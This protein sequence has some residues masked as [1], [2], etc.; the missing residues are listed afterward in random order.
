MKAKKSWE[1]KLLIDKKPI[2]K[3]ND[4]D[5]ADIPA[6][7]RM[8]IA[9]PKIMDEYVRKIPKGKSVDTGT[10]RK[11]L[12]AACRADFT[13][14]LTTGIFLRIVAEAAYE[15]YQKQKTLRGITPFWR[16]ITPGTAQLKKLSFGQEFL[17]EQRQKEKIT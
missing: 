7:S 12:A 16:A 11:D 2:V 8:L 5:F 17:V 9:T 10:I 14:P 13:C 3:R 6:N 15:K 4:F 1:E